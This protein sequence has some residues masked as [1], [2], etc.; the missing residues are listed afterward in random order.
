MAKQT[1]LDLR[2]DRLAALWR[3]LPK[4]VQHA[5]IEQYA[6]LITRAAQSESKQA[7]EKKR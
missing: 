6:R 4:R 2:G 3:R 5:I 1:C 7:G